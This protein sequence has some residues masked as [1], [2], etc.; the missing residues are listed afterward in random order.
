MMGSIA[1]KRKRFR[2]R[3]SKTGRSS[4]TRAVALSDDTMETS[5]SITLGEVAERT[6]VL[7]VAWR[8]AA[9]GQGVIGSTR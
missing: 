1:A 8:A 9:T 2:T 3:L 4:A 5:G 7:A 6:A